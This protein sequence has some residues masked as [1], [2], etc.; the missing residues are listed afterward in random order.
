MCQSGSFLRNARKHNSGHPTC[1]MNDGAAFFALWTAPPRSTHATK[2]DH[3]TQTLA[4]RQCD[5]GSL[6]CSRWQWKRRWLAH[7]RYRVLRAAATA[8]FNFVGPTR[9]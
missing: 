2:R 4:C 6:R 5:P 7:T 1:R 9:K 8:T 3:A